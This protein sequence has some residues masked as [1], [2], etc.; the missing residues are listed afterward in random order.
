MTELL[1]PAG[2]FDALKAAIAGGA[3][4][5][6]LG[7]KTFS[8]RAFADNFTLEE[9]REAIKIAHFWQVKVYVA[10]NTIVS[11]EEMIPAIFYAAELYRAGVDAIIVQD[12]GLLHLLRKALPEMHIHASTQMSIHNSAGCNILDEI[13]VER[14]ILAREL[15]LDDMKMVREKSNVGLETFVHGALCVCYSGQCLFSSMVGGRS[16]N[17]GRCAQPCR[18]AYSFV[19][20]YGEPYQSSQKGNYLLSPRDL[21]SYEHLADLYAVNMDS[22]KIEGRMKKPEYVAIVCRLYSQALQQLEETGSSKI[23]P[24]AMRQLLQ[25]FNRDHCLS[26]WQGNPGAALM[27]YARPNNRGVLL[28]RIQGKVNGKI[29]IRLV[30]PL[31]IGDMLEIWQSGKG[32]TLTVNEILVNGSKVEKADIGDIVEIAATGGRDN[33]RVFKIFD[34]LL[35]E[36]AKRSY[37]EFIN[38]PLHF[39]ITAK[40]DQPIT[41]R[42]F[43]DDGYTSMITSEYRVEKAIKSVSDM[44]SIRVQLGRLGGTG[45]GLGEL[46]GDVD[47]GIMIPSSVLNKCRRELTDDLLYQRENNDF[48]KFDQIRFAKAVK[49]SDPTQQEAKIIKKQSLTALVATEKQAHLAAGC[50]VEDIYFDVLGFV[51]RNPVDYRQLAENMQ[52]KGARLVP[53][54]PQIIMPR[55]EEGWRK[56]IKTWNSFDISAIMVNNLSQ[57]GMLKEEGWQG[58][59]FAGIGMNC[60]NSRTALMLAEQGV[61]RITLSPEMTLAQIKTLRAQAD[62][63]IFAQGALPLMVSEY[64]ALGALMG[65]RDMQNGKLQPCSRPCLTKGKTYNLRDEKGFVFPVHFDPACRMHVFNSKAHCLL[66]EIPVLKAAQIKNLL[67]DM[68]LYD[69]NMIKRL[70]NCY[71]LAVGDDLNFVEASTRIDNLVSDYTKGHLYRGV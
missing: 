10:V 50:G 39:E 60:F 41:I 7:G 3:K 15:S 43:D 49:D 56:R 67:L 11:D 46:T 71:H 34:S 24:D 40:L 47:K 48:R 17:R 53:Y 32:E 55:E 23:D 21:I 31:S 16:G 62:L 20:E 63:E 33:D 52:K 44:T 65:G 30:Q 14:V 61:S 25:A 5:V 19:N 35:M 36:E 2:S 8:A 18:M 68:R 38:K 12:L 59:T 70:L 28:G 58:E 64:C 45:Y 57:I 22:W 69:D 26:Y 9:I 29:R 37:T 13:G 51:G 66:K 27:S 42:A 54:L 6:Y 4:A 1:A